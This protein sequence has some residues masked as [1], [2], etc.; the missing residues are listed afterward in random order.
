MS[1]PTERVIGAEFIAAPR[2][3]RLVALH[4][5]WQGKRG[6]RAMPART[7]IDPADFRKL[8]PNIILCNIDASGAP[9]T[10]RLVG[11]EIVQFLG[12]N[13]TGREAGSGLEPHEAVIMRSL[14]QTV[15]G[16][17]APKFR[18]GQVWWQQRDR[19][20]PFE[21]CFLPL[22]ADGEAVNMVMFTILLGE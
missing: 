13:N 22:S 3:P 7:D 14:L 9:T 4:E 2:D 10:L 21:A 15:A 18:V 1:A 11:D 17:R 16:E 12:Q 20:R 6:A 19:F 5:Y 8:L